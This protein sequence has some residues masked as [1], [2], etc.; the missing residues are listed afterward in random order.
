V[1]LLLRIA[2]TLRILKSS[3]VPQISDQGFTALKM[4]GDHNII[5]LSVDDEPLFEF[6]DTEL[7]TG[8]P[9]LFT[10]STERFV[11]DDVAVYHRIEGP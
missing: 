5:R 8:D 11:F 1:P 9:G 7:L 2:T 3:E 10:Y 4:E 6:E